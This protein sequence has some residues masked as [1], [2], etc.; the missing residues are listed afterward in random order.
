M[1]G[2]EY[3]LEGG[4]IIL[5]PSHHESKYVCV[6]VTYRPYFELRLNWG[7]HFLLPTIL[8]PS[9]CPTN[10]QTRTTICQG[11][12][13]PGYPSLSL[14]LSTRTTLI[15]HGET[16]VQGCLNRRPHLP[17]RHPHL[18]CIHQMGSSQKA[19]ARNMLLINIPC[20][21]CSRTLWRGNQGLGAH[22]C[23][24]GRRYTCDFLLGIL[25]QSFLSIPIANEGLVPP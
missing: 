14:S 7:T 23:Q 25:S 13:T 11:I 20:L 19:R 6:T 15:R 3:A 21:N 4:G 22:T 10:W 9:M 17:H 18:S 24:K 2:N 8:L 1:E 5:V 12:N 16:L